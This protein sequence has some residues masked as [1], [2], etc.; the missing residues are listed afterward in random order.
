MLLDQPPNVLHLSTGAHGDTA[1]ARTADNFRIATFGRRHRVDD[2]LHL[3]ELLLGRHLRAAHLR[4]IDTTHG[5]QL[6]H[7]AAQ[8]THILHLLQLIAEVF[9][10]EAFTL[11][12]LL[13]QLVGFFLVQGLLGLLDQAEH[14]THAENPRGNP[15]RMEG[16]ERIAL[17]THAEEL[18]RLAGD[19]AHGQCRTTTGIT[20]DLG[21]HHAGQ[22]Q[23]IG[24]GL[25]GIGGILTGHGID[26]E[27]GFDRLD[28]RMHGL[29]LG[30]HLGID[31]QTT[32][33]IDNHHVDELQLGFADRRLGNRHRLL[34]EVR[35]EEGHTHFSCQGFQL[36]NSSRTINVRRHH[37]HGLFLA[38]FKEARQLAHRRG[39]ARALQASHQHHGGRSGMQVE[40]FVGRAHQLFELGAHNLHKSLARGQALRDFGAD[41]AILDL[42]DEV[43]D[44]RQSH[45]SFEQRH[46]HFAQGVFDIVLSQLGLAGNVAQGLREA[47]C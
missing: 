8:A 25:G 24:K 44:H 43:F 23:R 22:R 17:L 34:A 3:L 45:V 12:Q 40:V 15:V 30:H 27:Q 19:R 1:L 16:F 47:I 29:D 20:I 33:G 10:V 26:H 35:R 42:I 7:Q 9:E 36:F 39:L 2:R 38:L 21:Q 6:V 37:Q 41:R 4:Q 11:L 14:V 5:R 13:R 46:A 32:G 31:G 28:R 18:D